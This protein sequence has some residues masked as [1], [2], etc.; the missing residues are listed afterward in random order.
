MTSETE[1]NG[2]YQNRKIEMIGGIYRL[3]RSIDEKVESLL[4]AVEDAIDASQE[5][6]FPPR[7][8]DGNGYH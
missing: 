6:Y 7:N 2:K 1:N 4:H 8:W 3:A 5:D